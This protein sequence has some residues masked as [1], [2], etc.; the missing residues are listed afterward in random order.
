[1]PECSPSETARAGFRRAVASG[2][3]A[4][5]WLLAGDPRGAAGEWAGEMLQAL[6]CRGRTPPC[7]ACPACRRVVE[8]S[9]AD[10]VWIEPRS[11]ARQIQIEQ[12]R[13]GVIPRVA[14]TSYEGGWKA[15]VIEFADRMSESAQNALLKTLEE[16]PCKS[17]L[18]LVTDDPQRLLPTIVSR[19]Q[20][21]RLGGDPGGL[22]PE[23]RERIL[24]LC[25]PVPA[26][27]P[28][29]CL[30][31]AHAVEEHL[32]EIRRQAEAL[33]PDKAE[34]EARIR[35]AVQE[36]RLALLQLLM[37]W[38]RDVLA[39]TLGAEAGSLRIPD[40]EP[41]IRRQAEALDPASALQAVECVET[42]HRR[43]ERNLPAVW[44]FEGFFREIAAIRAR[45]PAAGEEAP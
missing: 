26:E 37:D 39:V 45:A 16:P 40:R 14:R 20:K 13:E 21:I 7:G 28:L 11:R 29:D 1:M 3:V 31:R 10:I 2:R 25:S 9:H 17:L 6:F 15:C 22:P 34:R 24:D 18:L 44:A 32:D 36:R 38:Q 8:R 27:N 35:S 4:H 23:R 5:A 42:L 43:L 19:C 41:E 33:E 30:A 12:V